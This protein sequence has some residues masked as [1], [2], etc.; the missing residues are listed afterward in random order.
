MVTAVQ[1][2]WDLS[3]GVEGVGLMQNK[4][5]HNETNVNVEEC[6]D[7]CPKKCAAKQ[8]DNMQQ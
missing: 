1:R 7:G 6:R 5:L 3:V 8:D 2:S 4:G